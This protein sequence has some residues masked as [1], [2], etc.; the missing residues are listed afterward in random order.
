M[1][2]AIRWND[3][4]LKH[5][6]P[7]LLFNFPVKPAESLPTLLALHRRSLHSPVLNNTKIVLLIPS[8]GETGKLLGLLLNYL[9]EKSFCS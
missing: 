9:Q 3:E 5:A 8:S 6:V 7:T 4:P 2:R 1:C